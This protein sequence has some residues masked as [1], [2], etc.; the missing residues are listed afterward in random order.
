[1]Q[2]LIRR[3][4]IENILADHINHRVHENLTWSQALKNATKSVA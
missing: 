3:K 1:M 2:T 4:I